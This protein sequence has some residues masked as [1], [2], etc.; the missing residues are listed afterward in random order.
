MSVKKSMSSIKNK[1]IL[2]TGGCG[3]IG[4][5]LTRQLC[6]KNKVYVLDQNETGVVDLVEELKLKGYWVGGRVGNIKDMET[7]RDI[8]SDFKPQYVFHAASYKH[9]SP[10]E[11]TPLEYIKTNIL[12]T[13]N[14]VHTAKR[15]ECVE[16]FVFISTDKAISANS[17]MGATKRLGEIMVKNQ[18]E[19][20]IAVRF[21]NVMGSRGSVIPF[22]QNQINRGDPLTVTDAR[23]TRYMMTIPEAVNLVIEAAQLGKGGEIIVL[24]M[25]KKVNILELANEILQKSESDVGVKMIGIRPGETLS[26]EIMFEEEKSKAVKSGK[27]YIIK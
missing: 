16:K 3:S 2:V 12:G 27:F 18:G 8:F 7:V 14:L 24:D 21:G 22:W 4:E 10:A 6:I 11:S 15:W 13:Y 23:M 1:R 20:F 25:G 17:F 19:G 26:E 5:E 9:V